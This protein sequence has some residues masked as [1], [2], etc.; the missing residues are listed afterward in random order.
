MIDDQLKALKAVVPKDTPLFAISAQ[1]GQGIKEVLYA[2]KQTVDVQKNKAA[3]A[4]DNDDALPVL[5][6]SG[7]DKA[8]KVVKDGKKYVITGR[9]IEKFAARTD[10]SNDQGLRRLRDIMQKM[11]ITHELRRQGIAPGDHI[12]IGSRNS[13]DY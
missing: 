9:K 8:W 1:S 7:E 13:F 3:E 5:T 4:K 2:I 10:F 12:T 6:L 11:G